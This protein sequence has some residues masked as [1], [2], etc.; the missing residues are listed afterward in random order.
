[1]TSVSKSIH[2]MLI[3]YHIKNWWDFFVTLLF[4]E[5]KITLTILQREEIIIPGNDPAQCRC[6]E[7]VMR[8]APSVHLDI[9]V[10]LQH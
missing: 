10:G 6:G 2:L 7:M 8:K 1:M 4:S 5:L 9:E 3:F